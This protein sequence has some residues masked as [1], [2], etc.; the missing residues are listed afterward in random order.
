M[1]MTKQTLPSVGWAAVRPWALLFL[2]FWFIT[3]SEIG[4]N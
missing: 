4:R 3:A 2:R 1:I